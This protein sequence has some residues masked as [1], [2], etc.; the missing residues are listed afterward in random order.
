MLAALPFVYVEL[1]IKNWCALTWL[2]YGATERSIDIYG[3]TEQKK[4]SVYVA[5]YVHISY[6]K[7]WGK[8]PLMSMTYVCWRKQE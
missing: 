8:K 7:V 5:L 4:K 1:D 2:V 6:G 3:L